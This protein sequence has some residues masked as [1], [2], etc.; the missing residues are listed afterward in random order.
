MS[1][2]RVP[3]TSPQQLPPKAGVVS[4][5][6]GNIFLLHYSV[7]KEMLEDLLGCRFGTGT[8]SSGRQHPQQPVL[9]P[10]PLRRPL[11]LLRP[12]PQLRSLVVP[13]S[14]LSLPLRFAPR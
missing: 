1:K 8:G 14:R 2:P 10:L 13:V 4:Q 6:L 7:L 11:P 3:Q 5:S 9:R 12:L